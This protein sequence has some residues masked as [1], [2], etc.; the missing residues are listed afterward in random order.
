MATKSVVGILGIWFTS[1]HKPKNKRWEPSR[2]PSWLRVAESKEQSK[3]DSMK[4]QNKA[5]HIRRMNAALKVLQWRKNSE[6][7]H[8]AGRKRRPLV[9]I[10]IDRPVVVECPFFQWC[11]MATSPR[12]SSPARVLSCSIFVTPYTNPPE[13][14]EQLQSSLQPSKPALYGRK[15]NL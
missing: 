15:I 10:G 9:P 12:F 2:G 11:R 4:N 1:K 8:P 13:K 6:P 3:A 14:A 5:H 7:T